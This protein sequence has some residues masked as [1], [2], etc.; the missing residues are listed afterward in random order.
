MAHRNRVIYQSQAVYVSQD[1]NS[2]GILTGNND[3]IDLDRIQSCNYSFSISRQDVNQ[4]GEL[5]SIDRIITETPTVSLEG[6]YLMANM[7][8][9]KKL[10]FNIFAGPND[11]VGTTP[12]SCISGI[13]NSETNDA[14]KNYYILTTKEGSDAA[15]NTNSGNYE[16]IV[17][18]GN[19]SITSYSTE[20]AVGGLP[21]TSFSIEG[22]N[23]NVVETPYIGA[24]AG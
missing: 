20:G 15:D 23:L 6:S 13:L 19:A 21:S 16:S 1:I 18:I 8:N 4:F 22:Q 14:V 3:N 12:V 2:T 17:G 7:G 24:N 11:A 5:A 9:E 10:G